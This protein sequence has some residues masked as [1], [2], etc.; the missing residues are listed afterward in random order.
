MCF[1]SHPHSLATVRKCE[2]ENIIDVSGKIIALKHKNLL[3]L[4]FL[5]LLP[6]FEVGKISVN[7]RRIT[8]VLNQM[9]HKRSQIFVVSIMRCDFKKENYYKCL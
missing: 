6:H 7:K 3:K 5:I 2:T 1:L 8:G 9:S 4:N